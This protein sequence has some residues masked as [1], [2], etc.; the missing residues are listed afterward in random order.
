MSLSDLRISFFVRISFKIFVL[1]GAKKDVNPP[2]CTII[3]SWVFD[4]FILADE[5]FGRA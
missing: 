4:N 5:L 2:N 3:G 1:S